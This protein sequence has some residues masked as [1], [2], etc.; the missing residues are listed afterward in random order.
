MHVSALTR[1][2]LPLIPKESKDFQSME[3]EPS[4]EV[5]P[6]DPKLRTVLSRCP[7][8]PVGGDRSGHPSEEGDSSL[9]HAA[10]RSRISNMLDTCKDNCLCLNNRG[11]SVRENTRGA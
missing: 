1:I 3:V 7:L 5:F 8:K 2:V 9:F 10:F 11:C 6:A 4:P